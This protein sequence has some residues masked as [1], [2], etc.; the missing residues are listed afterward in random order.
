MALD[1]L[2]DRGT[3]LEQQKFAWRELVRST[4]SKLDDDAFTRVR[5]IAMSALEAQ[6]LRFGHAC[7]RAEREL[8][9]ELA[10]VRR[11]EQERRTLVGWLNPPD[12]A[13]GSPRGVRGLQLSRLRRGGREPSYPRDRGALPRLRARVA[14]PCRGALRARRRARSSG[15]P[16]ARTAGAELIPFDDEAP[17]GASRQRRERINAEGS[18][19]ELVAA[20]H[21]WAPGSELARRLAV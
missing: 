1:L 6:A 7:A 4:Y 21:V 5:V 11:A 20:G 16:R 17:D 10:R 12:Q 15:A 13:L 8:A 2:R 14:P 3:P 9:L 18:P 19:S